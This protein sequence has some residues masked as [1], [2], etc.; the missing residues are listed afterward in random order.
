MNIF[1]LNNDPYQSAIDQCDKHVVKMILES[2]QM[3]C[4]AHRVM[5]GEMVIGKTAKGR[6]VKR[7][8]LEDESNNQTFYMATH[9][10]HPCNVWVRES[11]ENYVWLHQ[12]TEGLV[13]EFHFRNKK[14][15]ACE[16]LIKMLE[17][18]PS[19]IKRNGL[20]SFALCM[21]EEY[22]QTNDPVQSYRD[23]YYWEKYRKLGIADWNKGRAMPNWMGEYNER[24]KDV[25]ERV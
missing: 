19:N 10:N 20:T 14:S 25:M 3:M 9:V 4:T 24:Y 22:H 23:F 21:P 2:C 12:H 17:A 16:P 13:S 15:H 11:F 1:V 7:W 6:N 18:P 8:I 5:H